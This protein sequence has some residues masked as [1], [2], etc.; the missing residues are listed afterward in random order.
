ME[1]L[2]RLREVSDAYNAVGTFAKSK[3]SEVSHKDL[4]DYIESI[5]GY[6]ERLH[7][8]LLHVLEQA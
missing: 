8:G 3:H 1:R 5:K 2:E 6:L 7:I 4:L